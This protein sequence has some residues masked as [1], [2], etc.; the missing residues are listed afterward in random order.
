MVMEFEQEKKTPC[1]L[2]MCIERIK[3]EIFFIV[4]NSKTGKITQKNIFD[5]KEKVSF[6][7]SSKLR[8]KDHAKSGD[9]FRK[10][11]SRVRMDYQA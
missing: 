9:R 1:G 4:C 3:N 11:R 8:S 7:R 6:Q 10:C 2:K 5:E